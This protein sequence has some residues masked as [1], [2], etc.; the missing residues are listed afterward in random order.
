MRYLIVGFAMTL[1]A[2]G[3]RPP[4][5]EEMVMHEAIKKEGVLIP[6]GHCCEELARTFND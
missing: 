1:G 5:T 6:P 4:G 2:C 3:I